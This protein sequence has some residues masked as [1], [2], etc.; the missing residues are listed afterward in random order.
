MTLNG[1]VSLRKRPRR[2]KRPERHFPKRVL[3][4]VWVRVLQLL[5]RGA[6]RLERDT[7][8]RELKI[9]LLRL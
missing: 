9:L 4:E 1:V 3:G 7:V 2:E 6:L 8:E 5:D